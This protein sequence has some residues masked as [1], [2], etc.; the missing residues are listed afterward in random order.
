MKKLKK[1]QQLRNVIILLECPYLEVVQNHITQC[2]QKYALDSYWSCFEPQL[3]HMFLLWRWTSYVT[4]WNLSS[5]ISKMGKI[6]TVITS[7]SWGINYMKYTKFL[8]ESLRHNKLLLTVIVTILLSP[9]SF[10]LLSKSSQVRHR[11]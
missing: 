8:D 3:C 4:F 9:L 1:K 11:I 10:Y 5:S 2:L 7:M 6:T